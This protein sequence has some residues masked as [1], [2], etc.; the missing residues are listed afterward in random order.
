MALHPLHVDCSSHEVVPDTSSIDT[1]EVLL[2]SPDVLNND[3]SSW[4]ELDLDE[5]FGEFE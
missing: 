2:L 5:M 1:T 4:D 3:D